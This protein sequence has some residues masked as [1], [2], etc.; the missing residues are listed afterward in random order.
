M[1]SFSRTGSISLAIFFVTL[2]LGVS[3]VSLINLKTERSEPEKRSLTPP[4]HLTFD[5]EGLATYSGKF[6]QFF[7]DRF[8]FRQ[9]LVYL[10]SRLRVTLL[11]TSPIDKV[12]VGLDG[13][14]YYADERAMATDPLIPGLLEL[15]RVA[16]EAKRSW[17]AAQGIEYV[18]MVVP[19]KHSVYPEFLPANRR[20]N[21]T[22]TNLDLL[23]AYLKQKS[24]IQVL[25]VRP[26]LL[27]A[28]AT[29][30]VYYLTDTHWNRFG[31][32]VAN[33]VLLRRLSSFFPSLEPQTTASSAI[34]RFPIKG[35]DMAAMLLL[36]DLMADAEVDPGIPAGNARLVVD[37]EAVA[38]GLLISISANSKK[39]LPKAVV[40]HDSYFNF[41][42]PYFAEHFER[43]V[44]VGGKNLDK[45]GT[46]IIGQEHP[47]VVIEEIVE[48][49]L[50]GS[51]YV[52]RQILDWY[53]EHGGS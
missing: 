13:W 10:N 30:P 24:D 18:F 50:T 23:L 36:Q 32:A 34:K 19:D 40:F 39:G 47:Q 9:Q 48:R 15:W 4:P 49:Y 35:R 52:P 1:T 44:M 43:V 14:L 38:D 42:K 51:P 20:Q 26:Q 17:L 37:E 46:D 5:R 53:K 31:A 12:V 6:E 8:G 27:A 2:F 29:A 22:T 41:M 16:L 11:G 33:G 45:F 7:N 3:L 28:K 25:D 21:G